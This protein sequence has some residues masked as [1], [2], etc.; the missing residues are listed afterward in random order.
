M[1][2][3][4]TISVKVAGPSVIKF[5]KCEY[6]CSLPT[7]ETAEPTATT[8]GNSASSKNCDKETMD[9]VYKGENAATVTFTFAEQAYIHSVSVAPYVAPSVTLQATAFSTSSITLDLNGITSSTQTTSG[10]ASDGSSV[11]VVYSSSKPAVA[12]VDSSTGTVN[13]LSIGQT[14][15]SATVS[16]EGCENAVVSYNVLVKDTAE[17]TAGYT[18]DFNSGNIFTVY[19]N[20][21]D[22]G[23]LKINPGNKNAYG[24]NKGH[25]ATFKDGNSVELKVP[26][27]ATVKVAGCQYNN[28]TSITATVSSGSV[29]PDSAVSMTGSGNGGTSSCSTTADFSVTEACTL[30]LSFTGSTTYVATIDVVTN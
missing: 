10:S 20:T 2:P 16:K 28:N 7:S 8:N 13:A 11:T 25:G 14:T 18:V 6:G 24:L 17:P 9:F 1:A 27:N 15:I 5:G 29:T 26:A 22:F 21:L 23:K 3:G 12:T 4:D 19:G 30:T